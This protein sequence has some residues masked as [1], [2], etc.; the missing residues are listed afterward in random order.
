MYK[1]FKHTFYIE[2]YHPIPNEAYCIS[3]IKLRISTHNLAI[4]RYTSQPTDTEERLCQHCHGNKGDDE[5]HF[6]MKCF[7]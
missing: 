2:D 3:N 1:L 5:Y 6:L 4:E 7:K